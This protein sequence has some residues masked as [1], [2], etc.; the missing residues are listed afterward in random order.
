MKIQTAS[1]RTWSFVHFILPQIRLQTSHN[2]TQDFQKE[3][4]WKTML[5]WIYW[6][7]Q[8]CRNTKVWVTDVITW[9]LLL[10]LLNRSFDMYWVF[11]RFKPKSQQRPSMKDVGCQRYTTI[12]QSQQ[13]VFTSES[14][15]RRAYSN[16]A[17][18]WGGLKTGQKIS[19]Y[20]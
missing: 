8:Y 17:F 5:C 9:S 16:S 15:I 19:Y 13:W 7:Q 20:F 3:W 12:S 10:C 11:M 6:I 4:N 18:W 14:T 1:V 2:S